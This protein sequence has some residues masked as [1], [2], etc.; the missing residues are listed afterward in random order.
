MPHWNRITRSVEGDLLTPRELEI[1]KLVAVGHPTR[2]IADQLGITPG[3][4][5]SHLTSIYRKIGAENRVRA[6]RYYLEHDKPPPA[7]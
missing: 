1:L 6:T 2:V 3:T 7:A 4:V 5:K